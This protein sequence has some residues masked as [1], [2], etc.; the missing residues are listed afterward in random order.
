MER[1]QTIAR[2][3]KMR[4]YGFWDNNI[5]QL[6]KLNEKHKGTNNGAS[7]SATVR[8]CIDKAYKEEILNK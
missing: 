1:E 2:K 5:Y 4:T 8:Y 7:D 3:Q 6:E